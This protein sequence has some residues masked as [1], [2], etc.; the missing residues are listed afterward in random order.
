GWAMHY[1][2]LSIK[3]FNC[4]TNPEGICKFF[5][6]LYANGWVNLFWHAIFMGLTISIIMGGVRKGIEKA[7]R[8]LMPIL[9]G[10]MILLLIRSSFMSGFGE[11]VAFVFSPDA[12]KLTPAGVLEALG[13]AFFTL[14]LGMGAM[15]TYGSYLT[16][17]TDIVKSS[18]IIAI[19]D[20]AV[21]L[22]ACLMIFPVL[23]TYGMAPEA[24]PGLV[25]KSMPI[26]FAQMPGG[27]VFAVIFFTL[28]TLAA[29]TS[30]I[31]LMEVVTSFFI[32]TLKWKRKTATLIPGLL[33]FLFGIPSALSGGVLSKFTMLG[34]RN[35][36]DAMDYLA[37]N[38]LLPLGGLSIALFVG[39][40]M[41]LKIVKKEFKENSTFSKLFTPW[42]YAVRY[43]APLAVALVFLYKI[44]L[45]KF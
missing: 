31:S 34:G 43:L 15:L 36:F 18:I 42:F 9:F 17:K 28:L 35:F 30:A 1:V 45:L 13:H 29:L 3:N 38:W 37:S 11:A 22:I 41:D 5:G 6:D 2:F 12:S 10:M 4:V 26:V 16:H 32:D 33:V 44:G 7:A 40:R 27:T 24:G 25:F 8:L 19:M 21:A 20:T 14:S 39:Y 23:F